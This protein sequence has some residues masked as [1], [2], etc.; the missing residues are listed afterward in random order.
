MNPSTTLRVATLVGLSGLLLGCPPVEN[1]LFQ[2]TPNTGETTPPTITVTVTDKLN[3]NTKTVLQ[4]NVLLKFSQQFDILII[5]SAKDPGGMKTLS[6][7]VE[8]FDCGGGGGGYYVYMDYFNETATVSPQNT[9][10]NVLFYSREV[11]T[12]DVQK[13]PCGTGNSSGSGTIVL[14][15]YATNQSNKLADQS[16]QNGYFIQIA[17]GLLP[18]TGP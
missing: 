9:V 3:N 2:V 17:N 6:G 10:G 5:V 1:A 13:L 4:P 11:T 7:E 14:T 8:F 12:A 18:N 15:V 16:G